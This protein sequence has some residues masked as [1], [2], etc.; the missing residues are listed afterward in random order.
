M[1]IVIRHK[2]AC[3]L[4]AVS[5]GPS[6]FQRLTSTARVATRWS[7]GVVAQSGPI[8]PFEAI[9]PLHSRYRN[10]LAA[11]YVPDLLL[12]RSGPEGS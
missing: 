12:A 2:P 6:P 8:A 11:W 5:I 9:G 3:A 4:T 7:S 10:T 1:P